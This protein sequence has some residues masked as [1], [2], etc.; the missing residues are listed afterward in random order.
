MQKTVNLVKSKLPTKF[1]EFVVKAYQSQAEHFPNL[2]LYKA[3]LKV[4][5]A[6]DVRIHSECMT[7]DVFSSTKCDCGEQLEYSMK[8]I[9][10]HGGVIIYLRQEG[11]GIGL[12]NKLRAYNLQEE[13]F[14]TKDANLELGFHE[15]LR[16]YSVAI[17]ILKDLGVSQIRLL[18]NNPEKINAFENSGIDVLD[19]L[20]IEIQAN[21]YNIDYLKTKK[22]KMG[23]IL[24]FKISL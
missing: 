15:D 12:V 1:G 13:G 6:V 11:R 14:D 7:G 24:S 19:R 10:Q 16:E 18:T 20:P 5:K 3:E 2:V 4:D 17:D 8:W 21:A 23:H 9:Q 22:D